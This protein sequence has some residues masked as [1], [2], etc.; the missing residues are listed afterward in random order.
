MR[1]F[2]LYAG[3]AE[4]TFPG[5][6]IGGADGSDVSDEIA[7]GVGGCFAQCSMDRRD[8]GY[9]TEHSR[10][11]RGEQPPGKDKGVS[12]LW[13]RA[14]RGYRAMGSTFCCPTCRCRFY[15]IWMRKGASCEKRE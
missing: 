15:V 3:V 10:A 8:Q 2:S 1:C 12:K 14:C 7:V 5:D 9:V 4:N 6:A 13:P 11:T